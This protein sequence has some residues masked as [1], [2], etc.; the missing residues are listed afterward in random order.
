MV[1]TRY[2]FSGATTDGDIIFGDLSHLHDRGYVSIIFYSDA[3][4]TTP[5]TP[6]AGTV[7]FTVSESGTVYGTIPGGAITAADVGV[8]GSYMRPNWFGSV[9]YIK[10]TFANIAGGDYFVCLVHRFGG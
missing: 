1:A 2:R 5:V 9:R 4:F 10:A 7:D 3:A 8:G 6:T